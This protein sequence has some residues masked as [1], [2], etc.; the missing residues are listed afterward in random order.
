MWN[1]ISSTHLDAICPSGFDLLP[2]H[3]RQEAEIFLF[4]F[5]P[6]NTECRGGLCERRLDTII[7][8]AGE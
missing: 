5:P 2:G 6:P 1:T 7:D 3:F 8:A 4:Q